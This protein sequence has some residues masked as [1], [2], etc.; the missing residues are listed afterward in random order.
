M[1]NIQKSLFVQDLIQLNGLAHTGLKELLFHEGMLFG[2]YAKWWEGEGSRPRPHEGL[3]ILYY[4]DNKGKTR[5][6]GPF[7]KI[8]PLYQGTAVKIIKDLLGQ[9]IIVSH[10][11]KIDDQNIYSVYAHSKIPEEIKEG[12]RITPDSAVAL[13]ADLS[14]KKAPMSHH[15]HLSIFL[16]S[17]SFPVENV[18]WEIMASEPSITLLDPVEFLDFDYRVIK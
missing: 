13:I 12:A 10:D 2:S 6:L 14:D 7:T 15:L 3:D 16:L 8:P 1:P 18:T 4:G 11:L 17:D 5:S 9:S